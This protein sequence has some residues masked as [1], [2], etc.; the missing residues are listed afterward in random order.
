MG[1]LQLL[2]IT[3]ALEHI[4][5]CAVKT[6]S[7]GCAN[8]TTLPFPHKGMSVFQKL[9][10]YSLLQGSI[11]LLSS[12]LSTARKIAWVMTEGEQPTLSMKY[13]NRFWKLSYNFWFQ[14]WP[15]HCGLQL[16]PDCHHVNRGNS[17]TRV[18]LG[19]VTML[20]SYATTGILC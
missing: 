3:A 14:E 15:K 18:S 12:G 9:G 19:S 1:L 2:Q 17:H 10:L 20:L 11:L 7:S 4:L 13:S 8:W 5:H 6:K 16:N